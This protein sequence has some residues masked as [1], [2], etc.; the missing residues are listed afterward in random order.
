MTTNRNFSRTQTRRFARSLEDAVSTA[1]VRQ[2]S[3]R[4]ARREG[5]LRDRAA[6]HWARQE[7]E[8]QL[9]PAA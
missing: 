2:L 4:I 5:R 1:L 7:N 8:T 3:A 6:D 9:P